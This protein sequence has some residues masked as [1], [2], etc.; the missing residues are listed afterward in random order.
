MVWVKYPQASSCSKGPGVKTKGKDIESGSVS[1]SL[2][3]VSFE[4]TG[5]ALLCTRFGEMTHIRFVER[6]DPSVGCVPGSVS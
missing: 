4:L 5:E 6:P 1:R 3:K 2:Y